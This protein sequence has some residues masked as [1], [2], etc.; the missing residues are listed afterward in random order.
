MLSAVNTGLVEIPMGTTLREIIE[1]IGGGIPNGKKFKAAQTGGPSGGCIPASLIDTHIDYDSL[2]AIGSMMGS[3][4][5]IVMDEDN[6]MVDIAKFF[7]EFTVD[8]S[9]G[10]CTPCRV[11]TK[12]LLEYL[13]KITSG[14]ATMQDLDDLEE[15]CYYIKDNALCG[16]GQTAPNPILSTL[17][18][19]RDEYVAHIVDKKCPAGVCKSLLQYKI[20]DACKGC[21]L[22]ARK[23]PVNA[24][25]GAVKE[26]HVIDPAK[27]IKCGVCMSNCKFNAIIKE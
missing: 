16:L 6:C 23:C 26:K 17:K 24:I 27:C 20:T 22:C 21:T 9:C 12:R 19:F 1:D 11:G 25:S 4:G 8:E 18:Y 14:K 13:D 3:G 5:L 7:L 15:L 10:K 2:A